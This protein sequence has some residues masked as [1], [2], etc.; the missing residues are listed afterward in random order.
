MAISEYEFTV[1]QCDIPVVRRG[2][3]IEYRRFRRECLDYLD[4]DAA[5]SVMNQ[6]TTLAWHTTVFRTLNEGR[7][8]EPARPICGS[9][10]E[11]IID[12][13]FN[14][15]TLGVRRLVDR[16]DR[17]V[18]VWNVIAEVEKQPR[19][20]RRENFVCYDGLPYDYAAV[21]AKSAKKGG[22]GRVGWGT[23]KGPEAAGTSELLH[24]SFDGLVGYPNRRGRL[25]TVQTSIVAALKDRLQSQPVRDVC[26]LA[27]RSVAHAE[28]APGPIPEVT[29]NTINA[30]LQN[31]VQVASF[32]SSRF[33]GHVA[34]SSI[35]PL[36][37]FDVLQDLDQP[38]VRT[39]NLPA[40]H[41]YW[42]EI[43]S[44]MDAW[45]ESAEADLL[46]PRPTVRPPGIA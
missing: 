17:T 25:D 45:A 21:F 38:W 4:G 27:N 43:S 29:F 6:V 36:P 44:G 10:W 24:A 8:L 42:N 22:S 13:Y 40:L 2:A 34:F 30:A 16:D 15:M 41:E 35:V 37:Q 14:L 28:R 26:D 46:P 1:E 19:L 5:T 18:S 33:F 7:R 20:L 3:L 11:L 39:Q 9:M 12:G 32:L 31:I 23:V